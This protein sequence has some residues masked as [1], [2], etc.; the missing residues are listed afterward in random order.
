[1]EAYRLGLIPY[2]PAFGPEG[3]ALSVDTL[4]TRM[5]DENTGS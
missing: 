4:L 3:T 2:V 5:R 1:V